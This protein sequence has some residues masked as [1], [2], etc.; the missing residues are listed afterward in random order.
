MRHGDKR[1]YSQ[2]AECKVRDDPNDGSA[3][4]TEDELDKL[5]CKEINGR[6]S[7][8][9]LGFLSDFCSEIKET[10]RMGKLKANKFGKPLSYEIAAEMLASRVDFRADFKDKDIYSPGGSKPEHDGL[11]G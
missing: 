11:Y 2:L 8:L 4:I 6:Y 3:F 9:L 1:K 7:F 10:M 5:T